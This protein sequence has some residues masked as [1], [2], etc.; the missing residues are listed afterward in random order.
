MHC[1]F[2][3]LSWVLTSLHVSA[4]VRH[5]SADDPVTCYTERQKNL[6]PSLEYLLIGDVGAHRPVEGLAKG[7]YSNMHL[8]TCYSTS[9]YYLLVEFEMQVEVS[10]I[11]IRTQPWGYID[12]KFHKLEV[13]VAVSYTHLTLP[14]NRE[15]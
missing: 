14:T 3:D 9:N 6:F 5:I 4:G 8:D 10:S 2:S 12:N 1:R 7:I 11:L 15:V 13:R